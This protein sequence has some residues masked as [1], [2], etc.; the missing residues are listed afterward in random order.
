MPSPT[1]DRAPVHPTP[2]LGLHHYQISIPSPPRSLL[3]ATSQL[4]TILHLTSPLRDKRLGVINDEIPM[5][6][7]GG[8]WCARLLL[9]SAFVARCERGIL[10]GA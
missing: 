8:E 3:S 10:L 7:S 6:S 5:E 4:K 9:D 2:L 1:F